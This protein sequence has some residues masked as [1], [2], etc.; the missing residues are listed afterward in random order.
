MKFQLADQSATPPT[1]FTYWVIPSRLLAGAYPGHPD[2]AE[3]RAR[4]DAL[5]D[6]GI[7]LFVNLME[8]GETNQKGQP[9][10]PYDDVARGR[11]SEASMRRYAIRDLY[12]PT[13]DTMSEILD[14]IDESL[15]NDAPVYVHCWGGVGRTGTVIGCWM[16]RHGLAKPDDVL[17]VLKELR[18]QD[19]E[20][21]NRD[22][23]ENDTQRDFVRKW[24]DRDSA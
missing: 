17:K 12:I 6:A 18:L 7:R 8:T 13:L 24:L 15:A 2:P 9:F 10:V 20:R 16:L 5:V 22:S 1:S 21:S 14:A 11:A 4:I 23:P 19:Q 3:H